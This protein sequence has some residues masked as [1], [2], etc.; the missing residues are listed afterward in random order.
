MHAYLLAESVRCIFWFLL[1]RALNTM[2][3]VDIYQNHVSGTLRV[4]SD[5]ILI[6]SGQVLLMSA[7]M[8]IQSLAQLFPKT[9][10]VLK[11]PGM[12]GVPGGPG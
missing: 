10:P 4:N 6:L 8:D 12:L 1:S 2:Q 5:A 7:T 9:P 11:I 3:C